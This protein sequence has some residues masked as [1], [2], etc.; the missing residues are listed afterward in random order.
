MENLPLVLFI[1]LIAFLIICIVYLASKLSKKPDAGPSP[2]PL[3]PRDPSEA[4]THELT[5]RIGDSNQWEIRKNGQLGPIRVHRGDTLV[6]K[7]ES[8]DAFFQFPSADLF[9]PANQEKERTGRGDP[10]TPEIGP[11]GGELRVVVS[12]RACPGSYVYCVFCNVAK[13]DNI[14]VTGFAR[15]GSPPEFNILL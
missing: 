3:P 8:T 1:V 10:W 7:V 2:G 5:V 4:E 6:W 11:D 12:E 9:Y 13:K 14:P 15:G